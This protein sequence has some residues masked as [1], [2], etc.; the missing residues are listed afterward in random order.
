MDISD[1]DHDHWPWDHIK[2]TVYNKPS[3]VYSLQ[4][5]AAIHSIAIEAFLDW[6]DAARGILDYIDNK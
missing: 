5:Q 2:N 6:F 3:T 1:C 4:S